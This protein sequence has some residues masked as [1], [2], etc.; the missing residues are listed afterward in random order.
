MERK[1]F[2]PADGMTIPDSHTGRICPPGGM[3]VG[4]HDEYWQ[5]RAAD[6]GGV[7]TDEG[8]ADDAKRSEDL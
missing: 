5:R 2:T 7:L 1:W 8:P 6:G 3:W 4:A